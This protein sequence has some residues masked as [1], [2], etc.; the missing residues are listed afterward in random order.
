MNRGNWGRKLLVALLAVAIMVALL[1]VQSALAQENT[2][3]CTQTGSGVIDDTYPI[4][5]WYF[6]AQA[7]DVVTITMEKTT[8]NLDPFIWLY[9]DNGGS[10]TTLTENDDI[11]DTD[12][13]AGIFSFTL[14]QTDSEY[15]VGAGRYGTTTGGYIVRLQCI[16]GAGGEPGLFNPVITS[17]DSDGDGLT[18]AQE[19]ELINFFKPVL[20][21]HEDEDNCIENVF[22]EVAVAYQV[23]PY[24]TDE[25]YSKNGA[26]ITVVVLYPE[27]CGGLSTGIGYAHLGDTEALRIFVYVN[28]IT[29]EWNMGKILMKRHHESEWTGHDPNEFVYYQ[30]NFRPYIWVSESKHAMY[31]SFDQCEDYDLASWLPWI[32]RQDYCGFGLVMTPST[33]ASQNAGELYAPAFDYLSESSS[34]RLRNYFGG[35]WTWSNYQF[36]G[37]KVNEISYGECGGSLSGKWWPPLDNDACFFGERCYQVNWESMAQQ[38]REI[39]D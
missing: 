8:G 35:E 34:W 20:V 39:M 5:W 17:T 33:P 11:S 32:S 29:N 2:I 13:N 27:D 28:P 3:T 6:S 18:D 15:L 31:K 10:W 4:H 1:P 38:D 12:R 25:R 7:G 23:T 30:N 26:L 16:S 22:R 36:C 21:F 19:L 14:P 9:T 24:E 37:R